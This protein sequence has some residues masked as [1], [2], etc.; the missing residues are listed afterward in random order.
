MRAAAN[1]NPEADRNDTFGG[2][3]GLALAA[4]PGVTAPGR[5]VASVLR[6]GRAW[7]RRAAPRG[8]PKVRLHSSSGS[9]DRR[10][11]IGDAGSRRHTTMSAATNLVW[12]TTMF[13]AVD[14]PASATE[15]A[16]QA[17]VLSLV[18]AG[19]A[20][21][22]LLLAVF[23]GR[24]ESVSLAHQPSSRVPSLLAGVWRRPPALGRSRHLCN[25]GE[26]LDR[27]TRW[28]GLLR[29]R[30]SH[31]LTSS[32]DSGVALGGRAPPV[33]AEARLAVTEELGPSLSPPLSSDR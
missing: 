21:L 9:D 30:R 8:R 28:L 29:A 4:D 13:N 27:F 16:R 11:E 15:V 5:P 2:S 1:I 25:A 18:L 3:V 32:P 10:G 14:W 7:T 26:R 22:G 23:R 33:S 19:I 24:S 12:D 31:D 17:S 20:L 6:K